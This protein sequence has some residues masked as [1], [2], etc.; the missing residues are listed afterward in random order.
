MI[1]KRQLKEI[2]KLLASD[3][4]EEIVCMYHTGIIQSS[5]SPSWFAAGKTVTAESQGKN[6][7]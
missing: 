1:E 2:Y 4:Y 3:F 5:L 7:L 6:C